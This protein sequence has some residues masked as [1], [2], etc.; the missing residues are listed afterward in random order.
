MSGFLGQNSSGGGGSP[1][2]SGSL[3]TIKLAG[4]LSGTANTPTVVDLTI[5]GETQGA[6]LYFNGTNWVKLDPTTTG[7]VLQTNGVA[8]NPTWENV[9][10]SGIATISFGAAPGTNIVSIDVTGQTNITSTS[11]VKAYMNKNSTTDHNGIEHQ[12]LGL[13]LSLTTGDIVDGTGFT[14]YAYT[15][16]RLTGT[17]KINWEW[18]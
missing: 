12:M 16:L 1:A 15:D 14:I 7:K 17:F 3:G 4:D 9:L 18:R 10:N 2:T 13:A 11:V 8:A 6:L 5:S